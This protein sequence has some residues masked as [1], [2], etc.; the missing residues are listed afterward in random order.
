MKDPSILRFRFIT[1]VWGNTM[2]MPD[3]ARK[4]TRILRQCCTNSVDEDSDE[5]FDLYL[6]LYDVIIDHIQAID[7]D[8][9]GKNKFT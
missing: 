4:A 9:I 6:R 2:E 1:F 5:F 8:N 3:A 7:D